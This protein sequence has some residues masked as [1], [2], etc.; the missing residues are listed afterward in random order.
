MEQYEGETVAQ[1][2]T[3]LWQ[4][5][6]DCDYG[7]QGNNQTQDQIVQRSTSHELRCKLLEKGDTLT[8]HVLLKT[9]ESY[10]AMQAQLESTMSKT[11]NVN[12][13]RDSR[14]RKHHCKGKKKSG[15]NKTYMS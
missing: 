15:E 8:L 5:M 10:E 9:A 11:A 7:D 6:K 4:V 14:E 12:Q 13:T 3:R 1:F 2:V